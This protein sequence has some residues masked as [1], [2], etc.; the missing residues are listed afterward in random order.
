[1][2]KSEEGEG[3]GGEEFFKASMKLCSATK[4]ASAHA[5]EVVGD[6][7]PSA[8]VL[9]QWCLLSGGVMGSQIVSNHNFVSSQGNLHSHSKSSF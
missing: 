5:L 4:Q 2:A 9:A 8:W 6:L 7:K 3:E 1:M